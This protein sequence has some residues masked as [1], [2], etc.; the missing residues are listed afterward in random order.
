MALRPTRSGSLATSFAARTDPVL[1]E[2]GLT[3]VEQAIPDVAHLIGRNRICGP[4]EL[5]T[6]ARGRARLR[7]PGRNDGT[8][9][10]MAGMPRAFR[11]V[12]DLVMVRLVRE[13]DVVPLHELM[14]ELGAPGGHFFPLASRASRLPSPPRDDGFWAVDEGML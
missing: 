8:P 1:D 10:D 3:L 11:L 7:S 13:D 6:Q 14:S 4:G 12:G 2:L 5:E 9:A